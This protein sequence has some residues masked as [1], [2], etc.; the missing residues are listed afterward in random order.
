[1]SSTKKRGKPAEKKRKNEL[2]R[3]TAAYF[4]NMTAEEL[5]EEHELE[6]AI[7]GAARGVDFDRD[8]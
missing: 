1:M 2:E 8:E 3:D 7:S 6:R 5:K 4:E